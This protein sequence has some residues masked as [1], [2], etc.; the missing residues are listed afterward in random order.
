MTLYEKRIMKKKGVGVSLSTLSCIG[1]EKK[2][3]RKKK[4]VGLKKKD[5]DL[6]S[7]LHLTEESLYSYNLKTDL[8]CYLVKGL[9]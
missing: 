7:R 5:L 8:Q 4:I 1:K 9:N 3:F 2:S 6:L